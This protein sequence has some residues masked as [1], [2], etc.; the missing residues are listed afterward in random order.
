[1]RFLN[2]LFRKRRDIR[3]VN[4]EFEPV[5]YLGSSVKFRM[6]TIHRLEEISNK[7]AQLREQQ[8]AMAAE[9]CELLGC[10]PDSQQLDAEFASDIVY[11]GTPIGQVFDSI[12]QYREMR[13]KKCQ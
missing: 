7:A 2:N 3:H 6:E 9:C 5:Q 13:D 8:E 4:R 11:M 10:V 1:M 12:I